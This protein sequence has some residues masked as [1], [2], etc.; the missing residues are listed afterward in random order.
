MKRHLIL[1]TA[2]YAMALQTQAVDYKYLNVTKTDGTSQSI[3]VSGGLT[4]TFQNGDMVATNGTETSTFALTNL[5]SM[6]FTESTDI[7]TTLM[8]AS[9]GQ[10]VRL[11]N[12]SGVYVGT[13]NASDLKATLKAANLKKGI[14][15]VQAGDE[16]HK[17]IIK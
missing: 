5:A 4:I 16:T 8:N 7:L 2:L 9:S 3:D 10:Y 13:Y 14:Y 6:S 11:Y 17:V 1:A 15:F 12:I